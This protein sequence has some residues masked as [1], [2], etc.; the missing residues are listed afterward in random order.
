MCL[1]TEKLN[2]KKEKCVTAKNSFF[3]FFY[4]SPEYVNILPVLKYTDS[5]VGG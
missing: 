4:I 1:S 2:T 5:T 3:F